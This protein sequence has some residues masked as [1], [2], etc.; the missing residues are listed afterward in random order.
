MRFSLLSILA[1]MPTALAVVVDEP[2][3]RS[4]RTWDL[5][6]RLDTPRI[7]FSI[8]RDFITHEFIDVAMAEPEKATLRVPKD[9]NLRPGDVWLV[10]WTDDG[11][12]P[13]GVSQKFTLK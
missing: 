8:T 3:M 1:L 5:T 11:R 13:I 9:V 6:W 2:K 12:G 10:A 7:G 4:R